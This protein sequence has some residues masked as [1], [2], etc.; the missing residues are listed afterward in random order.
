MKKDLSI[1]ALALIILSVLF[2]FYIGT[3]QNLKKNEMFLPL[4]G[5]IHRA[6]Q[7]SR[8]SGERCKYPGYQPVG[9]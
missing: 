1:I 8:R 2:F 5:G 6:F 7:Y 4:A 3:T 9:D